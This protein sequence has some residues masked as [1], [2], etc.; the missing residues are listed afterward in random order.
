VPPSPENR[1][2]ILQRVT[3]EFVNDRQVL[4]LVVAIAL[5]L[6]VVGCSSGSKTSQKTTGS[7]SPAA[8][9]ALPAA[10]ELAKPPADV[11]ADDFD[12]ALFDP[13][14]S[15]IVDNDWLP[16]EPGTRWVHRGWT[17]EEGKRVPHTIVFVITDLVKEINGVRALVGW[18]RDFS[19]GELVEAEVITLAQDRGGNVWHLGQYSEVY[20]EGEFGGGSAWFVGALDGAKAGIMMKA[21]PELGSPAYSEGFAPAPYFWDD[22]AKVYKVG[23]STCVPVDCFE[24]VLVTD[25]FEPRKPGAH[26]LKYYARGVGNIRTGWRGSDP[27]REEL[28]LAKLEHLGPE[29]MAAARGAALALENRANVYGRTG[30]AETTPAEA[31]G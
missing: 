18:E 6:G 17:E 1:D 15:F 19:H 24:D 16:L 22:W 30:P 2:R 12:P 11:T 14:R 25:E 10:P 4:L 29:Q 31:S 9:T 5:S 23:E 8:G 21:N 3:A 27:D 7:T 13:Q 20:E 28:A 26:Q